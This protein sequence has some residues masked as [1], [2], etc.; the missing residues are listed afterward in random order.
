MKI[1]NLMGLMLILILIFV[2][3][4]SSM[5]YTSNVQK[6]YT[7]WCNNEMESNFN[8]IKQCI[9][10]EQ[11]TVEEC[12]SSDWPEIEALYDKYNCSEISNQSINQSQVTDSNP[13]TTVKDKILD[14]ATR[15]AGEH[16]YIAD[17]YDC[18]Q[19]TET[20]RVH[21]LNE[22]GIQAYGRIYVP[23]FEQ[24]AIDYDGVHITESGES[25]TRHTEPGLYGWDCESTVWFRWAFSNVQKILT[26]TRGEVAMAVDKR[27]DL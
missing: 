26:P 6:Q 24:L 27:K 21:L 9:Q 1:Q 19:F 4:L 17:V 13:I 16:E 23:D 2:A 20:L 25:A 8:S 15:M 18:T 14:D 22:Y 7:E 11:G 5:V 12:F 3:I 10:D